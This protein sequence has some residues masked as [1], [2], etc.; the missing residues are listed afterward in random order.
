[1]KK[2]SEAQIEEKQLKR[3]AAQRQLYREGKKLQVLQFIISVPLSMVVSISAL[4]YPAIQNWAAA[5]ALTSFFIYALSLQESKFREKAAKIQELFDC[6]VLQMEWNQFAC[7]GLPDNDDIVLYSNKYLVKEKNF[8]A[9]INP[10][11]YESSTDDLPISIGRI[12]CQRENISWEARSR[13]RYAMVI[14]AIAIVIVLISVVIACYLN[15]QMLSFVMNILLPLFPAFYW[16]FNIYKEN[17][18]SSEYM[19]QIQEQIQRLLEK[20]KD[21]MASEEELKK[22]SRELQNEIFNKRRDTQSVF[23]WIY[24]RFR[25][26]DELLERDKAETIVK[27]IL[28]RFFDRKPKGKDPS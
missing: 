10:P 3:L 22:A 6:E 12:M 8:N 23:D 19:V 20:V 28:K 4:L 13:R 9:F 2:I 17:R 11:W 16:S 24:K 1:M 25:D 26:K 7:N 5:W 27:D 21:D 15:L 18:K 14:M